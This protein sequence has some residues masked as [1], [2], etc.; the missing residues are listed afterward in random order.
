MTANAHRT[1][2]AAL[3]DAPVFY[4]TAEEFSDP[5]V[6]LSSIEPK[7]RRYGICKI[8]PPPG[9]APAFNEDAWGRDTERFDTKQQHIDAL[10]EGRTFKFG[11]EYTKAEYTT[12]A[13]EFDKQFSSLAGAGSEAMER[14]FWDVVETQSEK[15]AVDYGNDLDVN[16]FGSMFAAT[17]DGLRHPWDLGHLF[18][19]PLNLLRVIEHEIAGV[20]KPWLYLGMRFATFCWHVEDHF[21][22]SLNYLHRGASKTWYGIPGVDA[23]AFENCARATVPHL[24]KDAPD[25]LHQIITMVPPG[26]LVQHGIKVS[27]LVQNEGEFVVTF[28]RAYHAGFSHGFNV[29]EAVNFGHIGWLNFGQKA[30]DV[31]SKGAFKRNAVFAH[32]RLIV[33]ASESFARA[34]DIARASL[35]S[36]SIGALTSALRK[37]MERMLSDEQ[38]FRAS[39][40]RRGLQLKEVKP[41]ADNDDVCCVRCKAIPF[42][43]VVRCRCLPTAVRCLS[44]AMDACSC[45]PE[46]RCLE[47][48]ASVHQLSN[49]ILRLSHASARGANHQGTRE[50]ATT[51]LSRTPAHGKDAESIKSEHAPLGTPWTDEE[52]MQLVKGIKIHN[53][54]LKSQRE[55]RA[56]MVISIAAMI[57]TR[58]QT[59]VQ[60]KLKK[61]E[62]QVRRMTAERRAQL[63]IEFTPNHADPRV[64]ESKRAWEKR[65]VNTGAGEVK[66]QKT[67]GATGAWTDEEMKTL[68]KARMDHGKNWARIAA[69]LQ[70]R[71]LEQVARK[72][73]NLRRDLIAMDPARRPSYVMPHLEEYFVALERRDRHE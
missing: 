30:V 71:T 40:V 53:I 70:T 18:A 44:H 17:S 50:T 7:V 52:L 37:E 2:D 32:Q 63:G 9:C 5:M 23:E 4:P 33:D 47:I 34:Y 28:P 31:Y 35:Q 43:S 67:Q 6:Y 15:I 13:I 16:V 55:S 11:K 36:K 60:S 42:L 46:H 68:V 65:A 21:L 54:N 1:I 8:V 59:Q 27:R 48:R 64:L 51:P 62:G 19:H 69:E 41:H 20:T 72:C 45:E 73:N 39:L 14:R 25:I 57:P 12:A 24:F 49:I 3:D 56:I 29:A 58:T 10:K 66:R 38:Y 26:V 22:C 61:F